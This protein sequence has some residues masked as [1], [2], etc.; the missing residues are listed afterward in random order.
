M[1]LKQWNIPF[2]ILYCSG[3]WENLMVSIFISQVP[4]KRLCP[5]ENEGANSSRA[6]KFFTRHHP[7]SAAEVDEGFSLM[8][9]CYAIQAPPTTISSS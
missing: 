9:V 6:S 8:S 2:S 5:D 3:G 7:R 4:A 1:Q